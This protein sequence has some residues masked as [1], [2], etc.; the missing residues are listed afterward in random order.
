[1]LYCS[2]ECL[3][4]AWSSYH[5][6]ECPGTQVG[7]GQKIGIAHLSLKVLLAAS[8]TEDRDRFNAVQRLVTNIDKISV[9]DLLVYGIVSSKSIPYFYA[10]TCSFSNFRY[11]SFVILRQL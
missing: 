9:D 7:I 4:K 1:M 3:N 11:S 5:K 8:T 6:W 10:F 2:L